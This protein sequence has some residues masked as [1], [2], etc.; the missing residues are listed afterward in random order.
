[1]IRTFPHGFENNHACKWTSD[2]F[3]GMLTCIVPGKLSENHLHAY[4]FSNPCG[5]VLKVSNL[6]DKSVAYFF[7]RKRTFSRELENNHACELILDNYPGIIQMSAFLLN[8]QKCICMHGCS[9][10]HV[11]RTLS[12][13]EFH[14]VRIWE[15]SIYGLYSSCWSQEFVLYVIQKLT[16]P[17]PLNQSCDS[18]ISQMVTYLRTYQS[19]TAVFV[20]Q[21]PALPGSAENIYCDITLTNLNIEN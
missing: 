17:K 18:G 9:Q 4:L 19:I 3:P 2:N 6:G 21:P 8:L 12:L 1:M 11:E 14:G 16:S 13:L 7:G 10:I 15:C 20:E 5:Q